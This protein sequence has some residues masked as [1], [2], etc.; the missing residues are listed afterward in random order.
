[1][2]RRRLICM[3]SIRKAVSV[4]AE[5]MP[6]VLLQLERLDGSANQFKVR[7][8]GHDAGRRVSSQACFDEGAGKE[9]TIWQSG[10]LLRRC[11]W[12]CIASK[13]P[14]LSCPGVLL[15]WQRESWKRDIK[16]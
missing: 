15:V 12:S 2:A 13:G 11:Q 7:D 3:P 8:I 16:R 14:C 1:M 5:H 9:V 6:W 10:D 4:G